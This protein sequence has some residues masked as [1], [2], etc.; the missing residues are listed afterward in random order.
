[1]KKENIKTEK[2]PSKTDKTMSISQRKAIEMGEILM[3]SN[4]A[5]LEKYINR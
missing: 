1:M 5:Q 2:N 4:L 3:N